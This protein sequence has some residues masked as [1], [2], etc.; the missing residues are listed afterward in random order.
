[1]DL[2]ND[3][4]LWDAFRLLEKFFDSKIMSKNELQQ[5]LSKNAQHVYA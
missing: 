5:A 1:M 2:E 4:T 3:V